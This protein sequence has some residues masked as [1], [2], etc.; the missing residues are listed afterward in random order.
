MSGCNSACPLA[1]SGESQELVAQ[2]SSSLFDSGFHLRSSKGHISLTS[3]AGNTQLFT[4][5]CHKVTVCS[6][7]TAKMVVKVGSDDSE[8]MVLAKFAK[9][10]KGSYRVRSSANGHNQLFYPS[11]QLFAV[12]KAPYTLEGIKS[13]F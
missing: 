6:R 1:L 9:K 13:L 5:I 8:A 3:H 4:D 10:K 7:I 2:M 12:G 11:K